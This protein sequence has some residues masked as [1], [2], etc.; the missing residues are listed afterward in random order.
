MTSLLKI[1]FT[2]MIFNQVFRG[3]KLES[4]RGDSNNIG[5]ARWTETDTIAYI[6]HPIVLHS[7]PLCNH[8]SAGPK[9]TVISATK[10]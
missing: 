2:F 8:S 4:V 10:T 7:R 6:F 3:G 9:I 5:S 1:I